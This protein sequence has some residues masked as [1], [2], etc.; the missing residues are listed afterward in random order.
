M[1]FRSKTRRKR[2][3]TTHDT[4]CNLLI[5]ECFDVVFQNHKEGKENKLI[6]PDSLYNNHRIVDCL[7]AIEN[8][9]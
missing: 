8:S 1:R 3:I 2:A 4:E 7:Y 6:L 5:R 9:S